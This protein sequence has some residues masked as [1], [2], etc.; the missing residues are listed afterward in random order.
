[1]SCRYQTIIKENVPKLYLPTCN[2]ALTSVSWHYQA[3]IST[4]RSCESNAKGAASRLCGPSRILTCFIWQKK[5]GRTSSKN[6][7]SGKKKRW[8]STCAKSPPSKNFES[9]HFG[10]YS[11]HLSTK[12]KAAEVN[13]SSKVTVPTTSTS[14]KKVKFAT[15]SSSTMINLISRILRLRKSWSILCKPIISILSTWK[16]IERR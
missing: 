6:K 5:T 12:W 9:N 10:L 4:D 13:Y 16:R 7:K 1:M 11:V 3:T 15:Q 8:S 2:L 14:F